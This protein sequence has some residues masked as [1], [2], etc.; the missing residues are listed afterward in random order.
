MILEKIDG[1][2]CICKL[3]EINSDLLNNE[4][5]FVSRTDKEL[6]VICLKSNIP[7]K[8]I[9]AEEG[10]KCFRIAEDAAFEKYGMIAFLAKIIAEQKTGVLVVATYDTDYLLVKDEKFFDVCDALEQEGCQFL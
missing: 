10:W 2:F 5:T 4:Y 3:K 9:I 6:S 8:V 1:D 7:E